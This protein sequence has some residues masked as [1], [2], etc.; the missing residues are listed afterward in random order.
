[1][2]FTNGT[3]NGTMRC[4]NIAITN[5]EVF[6]S[7]ETFTISIASHSRVVVENNVVIT[8][9]DDEGMQVYQCPLNIIKDTVLGPKCSVTYIIII[10]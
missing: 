5:D 10:N 1:M 6:E 2:E 3:T 7:N 8:I 9:I 4:I